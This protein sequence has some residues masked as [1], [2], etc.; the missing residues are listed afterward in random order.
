MSSSQLAINGGQP[1]RPQGPPD[2]PPDDGEVREALIQAANDRS[3]GKYHGPHCG[4]LID[5]LSAYHEGA[6]CVLCSSGTAA[7]ELALRAL[8]VQPGDEVILAAYDFKGNFQDVLAIGA[9]PAL[10]DVRADNWNIDADEI[11]AAITDKTKAIIVSHLHGGVVDMPSVMQIARDHG[12]GVL[13]D[14]CQVTGSQMFGTIA[15]LAG[16]VG[17]LSFGGSKLLSA[18]RGGAVISKHDD[19][20][21]R[22]R[23]YQQRG[24]D[25]YPMSELQ[26]LV[27]SPQVDRLEERNQRRL[28]NVGLLKEAL[29]KEVG[30]TMFE[31]TGITSDLAQPGY[32]KVGFRYDPSAFNDLTRDNFSTAMRAEGI[33]LDP[34]FRSL[35]RI[36]SKRRFLAIGSSLPHANDADDD[37]LTLHHPVL[38]QNQDSINE[39]ARAVSKVRKHSFE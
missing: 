3:W 16:H 20:I 32:Y 38:L 9:V 31:N 2:W 39:I 28:Q 14:A 22:V 13:E 15:G 12:L 21:Q 11:P 4:R 26:A 18:G 23:L 5:Q 35:H 27:L 30:L 36:H 33:A 8:K 1:V 29:A 24:N 19:V 7:V 6:H 34:G 10:V 37:V 25:A 17:V